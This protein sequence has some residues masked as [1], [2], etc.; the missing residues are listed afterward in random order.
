MQLV[1]LKLKF[2]EGRHAEA[3]QG[4][5]LFQSFVQTAGG[6]GVQGGAFGSDRSKVRPRLLAGV[7]V[8]GLL[9]LAPYP[10][11][12]GFGQIGEDVLPLV[13]PAALDQGMAGEDSPDRVAQAASPVYDDQEALIEGK[14]A[15]DE[16]LQ[17]LR[18]DP[19]VLGDRLL[20]AQG[21]LPAVCGHAQDDEH[22][23]AFE[24]LAVDDQANQVQVGQT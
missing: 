13:P 12:I 18:G 22:L 21:D 19:F 8:I 6:R 20:E 10:G 1:V 7:L 2:Q 24:G 17:K 4:E 16:L 3:M 23:F 14:A 5:R 11:L 15:I 9:Q